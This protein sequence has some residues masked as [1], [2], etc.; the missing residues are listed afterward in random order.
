MTPQYVFHL[1]ITVHSA[2]GL[3]DTDTIGKADPYV[4]VK[5]GNNKEKR[6]SVQKNS[7]SNPHWNETLRFDGISNDDKII[8]FIVMDKDLVGSDDL[9][10]SAEYQ[11]TSLGAGG[12]FTGE[13]PLSFKSGQHKSFLKVTISSQGA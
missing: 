2:R 10:G 9:M 1:S 4:V 11:F 8:K 7:G 3:P 6:T 5:V 12:T 13:L